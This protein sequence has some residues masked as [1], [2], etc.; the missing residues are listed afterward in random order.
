MSETAAYVAG[1]I[2]IAGGRPAEV[3][4][5]NAVEAIFQGSGGVPR[6]INVICHNSLIG[7]FATQSKPIPRTLVEEVLRDFDLKGVPDNAGDARPG[8]QA[9]PVPTSTAPA[10]VSNE[11]TDD[12][13]ERRAAV[14]GTFARKRRFSFFN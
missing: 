3:F 7:G 9:S 1:R 12:T 6:V 8:A 14:F 11:S 13:P 2:R 4:T 5:R 10:A